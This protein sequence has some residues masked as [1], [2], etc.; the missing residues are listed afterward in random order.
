MFVGAVTECGRNIDI[1]PN[2]GIQVKWQM[3]LLT[4]DL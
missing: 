3:Y 4:A 2:S 1:I